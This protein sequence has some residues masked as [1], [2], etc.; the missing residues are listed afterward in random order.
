MFVSMFASWLSSSYEDQAA[1]PRAARQWGD[2][3]SAGAE[4]RTFSERS[5]YSSLA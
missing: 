3:T 2:P 1:C 4:I 5:A